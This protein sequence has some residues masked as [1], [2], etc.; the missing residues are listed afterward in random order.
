MNSTVHDLRAKVVEKIL[1]VIPLVKKKTF[2]VAVCKEAFVTQIVEIDGYN[3]RG[4]VLV[5]TQCDHTILQSI[6]K[7]LTEVNDSSQLLDVQLSRVF[8]GSGV[9][10]PTSDVEDAKKLVESICQGYLCWRLVA[11]ETR[12]NIAN[13]EA[14]L[15]VDRSGGRGSLK[16]LGR[17][18]TAAIAMT[19]ALLNHLLATPVEVRQTSY[20]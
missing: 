10:R 18:R 13:Y 1:R 9:L 19:L 7:R 15:E 14:V 3:M 8:P 11:V 2:V 20:P 4:K 5:L 6:S 12:S 17:G 16:S